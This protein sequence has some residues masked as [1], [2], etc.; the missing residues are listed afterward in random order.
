M[1]G[2]DLTG[3]GQGP[4]EDCC[5]HGDVHVGSVTRFE[6]VHSNEIHEARN[7]I[8]SVQVS[9]MKFKRDLSSYHGIHETV[10]LGPC[11]RSILKNKKRPYRATQS[12]I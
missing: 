5:E 7:Y 2:V 11:Y 4:M 6:R 10:H 8:S 12:L 1:C 9:H 3:L